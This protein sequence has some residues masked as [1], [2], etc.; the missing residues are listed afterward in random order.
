MPIALLQLFA[1]RNFILRSVKNDFRMRFARSK[2]AGLWVVVQPL[3]QV[4]IF[5]VVLS[6]LLNARLVGVEG[7][8]AYT[9]YLLAGT[10]IWTLFS[11]SLS[12]TATSFIEHANSIKKIAFPRI[13]PPAI[14][15]GIALSNSAILLSLSLIFI[16]AAHGLSATAILWLVPVLGVTVA[17]GASIGL[18]V[19]TLNVFMRDVWQVVSVALQF[20]YW[21]TPIVYPLTTLSKDISDAVGNNPLT[22]LVLASQD[23]LVRGRAPN[24]ESLLLPA[25]LAL[26]I[27]GGAFLLFR[28]AA[29]DMADAL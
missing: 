26:L 13:C 19:G 23:I 18:I 8:Y 25:V 2:A 10:I 24:V 5:A 28:R 6:N 4:A 1:Y 7:K 15:V 11:D 22:P 21:F 17:L 9:V 29:P 20:L 12:R 27:G 3:V 16:G 14:G